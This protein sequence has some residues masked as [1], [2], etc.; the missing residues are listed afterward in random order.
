MALMLQSIGKRKELTL[1]YKLSD[2]VDAQR[3]TLKGSDFKGSVDT[4]VHLS[5]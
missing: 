5:R 2:D 3:L 4:R 1:V